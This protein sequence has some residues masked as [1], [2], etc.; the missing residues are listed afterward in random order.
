[1]LPLMPMRKYHAEELGRP[2]AEAFRRRPKL[3][4]ALVLDNV[5][6][7]LNVGAA[8]RTADAFAVEHIALC[9]ITAVPPHR[10]IAKTA[11]GATETVAWSYFA[12]PAE[13]IAYYRGMNYQIWAV[14][15]AEGSTPLQ[16]FTPGNEERYALVFGNEVGGVGETCMELADGAI[17]VPQWGAKHSLNVSVCIGIVLWEIVRKIKFG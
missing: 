10:E 16:D 1:M 2:D 3:P 12:D 9:G 7:A 6:S 13:A 14:E 15:Q 4:V 5:R 17:E 8:F 11:L